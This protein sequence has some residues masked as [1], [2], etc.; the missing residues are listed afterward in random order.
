[1]SIC[2]FVSLVCAQKNFEI[3]DIL[4]ILISLLDQQHQW[5]LE[6]GFVHACQSPLGQIYLHPWLFHSVKESRLYKAW[7]L[8][9]ASYSL[10]TKDLP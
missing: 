10:Q 9:T 1:M 2:K 7:C 4:V 8:H 3:L 5:W 6:T